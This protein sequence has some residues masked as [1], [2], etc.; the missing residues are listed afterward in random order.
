MDEGSNKIQGG[1]RRDGG[2]VLAYVE[3][4][5]LVNGAMAAQAAAALTI[6]VI[7]GSAF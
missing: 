2:E 1:F 3:E 7:A 6:A 4:F 5:T